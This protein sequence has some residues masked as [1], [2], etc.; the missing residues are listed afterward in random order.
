MEMAIERA[1]QRRAITH[2]VRTLA[3]RP[4]LRT[5]RDATDVQNAT[6]RYLMYVLLPL[7]FVPGVLDWMW[8][9]QTDIEHTSG[10]KESL[11]HSL[12][13]TEVG[14]P[15]LMGL[16]LEVNSLVL[17]LMMGN[18]AVH[19]LTAFWDVSYAVKHRR[20][21]PREQHTHS[22]LEVLPF[23]AVSFMAVLH[24]DQFRAIFGLGKKRADWTL[25]PKR[26]RLPGRYLASI[27]SGV[28]AFIVA[29]YAEELF[30]CVRA[31]ARMSRRAPRPAIS[32]ELGVRS[33]LPPLGTSSVGPV[34]P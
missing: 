30:R 33:P 14:L 12:M 20:V 2:A 7:W 34:T 10:T 25:R 18:L 23:M 32:P 17:A 4:E 16:F 6:V 31:G 21:L 24:N 15:I 19:E 27:L 8:H 28:A 29:P 1:L 11:I 5:E 3:G 22:L 26:R 9:R 13:M